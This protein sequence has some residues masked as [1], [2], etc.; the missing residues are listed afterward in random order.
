[1]EQLGIVG[2]A[3]AGKSSLLNA[4]TRAGAE[5]G[6]HAFSSKGATVG[7]ASV[8]DP[9]LAPLA[10]MSKSQKIVPATCQFVDIAGLVRGASRGEGLGNQ[11]LGHLREVDALCYVLRV[12]ED[13]NVSHPEGKVDPVADLET[14]ET[15][16]CLADLQSVEKA[17]E[18]LRKQARGHDKEAAS[19]VTAHERATEILS[20]GV[21]L[22]RVADAELS[23]GLASSFLLTDKPVLY[24]LNLGEDQVGD[25]V[26][27]ELRLRA[28]TGDAAEIVA[29]CIQLEAEASELDDEERA[30][31]VEQLGLGE[32]ALARLVRAAF[33]KLG[34]QTF[35]TT[36][37]KETRAWTIKAGANAAEAAG[38]IHTDLQ[39]GF[40]RAEVIQAEELLAIG[41]WNAAKDHGRIRVEG[42]A[43]VMADG[44]V[45][46]VRHNA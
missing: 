13:D 46:L 40:I 16:L 12:F 21:P 7:V 45:V 6:A 8:P 38:V 22:Y 20:D 18:R 19:A 17:I 1:M 36:G 5:V 42:R 25:A 11:F 35:L 10:E 23:R 44:D 41:S 15:E 3:N 31:M 4:L 24:V 30:E 32:G 28:V 43:Y 9:R 34:L 27:H 29:L 33:H 26:E 2:L 14:L 37:P 39:K